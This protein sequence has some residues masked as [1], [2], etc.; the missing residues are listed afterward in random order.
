MKIYN[1]PK[2]YAYSVSVERGFENS[3]VSSQVSN[4][5][6]IVINEEQEW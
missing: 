1:T 6:D 2:L 3:A 4:L 5:E